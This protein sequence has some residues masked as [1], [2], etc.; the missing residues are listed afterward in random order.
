MKLVY[1]VPF[2]LLIRQTCVTVGL[3]AHNDVEK[4]KGAGSFH[5]NLMIEFGTFFH[6]SSS[7]VLGTHVLVCYIAC[8]WL[9]TE[10]HGRLVK[11]TMVSSPD[12]A[13]CDS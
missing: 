12:E 11:P 1:R 9:E 6:D 2:I 3:A 4:K 13:T 8:G 10:D 5:T 7:T